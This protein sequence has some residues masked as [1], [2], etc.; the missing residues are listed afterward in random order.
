MFVLRTD[1]HT[2]NVETPANPCWLVFI[3]FWELTFK[4]SGNFLDE[5]SSIADTTGT[6]KNEFS[7]EFDELL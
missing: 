4:K 2:D 7:T 3:R 6:V 5:C 1:T